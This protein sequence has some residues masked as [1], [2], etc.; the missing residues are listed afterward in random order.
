MTLEEF[1]VLLRASEPKY[2]DAITETLECEFTA[3]PAN[4]AQTTEWLLSLAVALVAGATR[5][6]MTA[7]MLAA[8]LV[9]ALEIVET[10]EEDTAATEPQKEA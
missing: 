6:N 3:A 5:T 9:E 4:Q 10:N 7:D 1:K 2:I 8:L